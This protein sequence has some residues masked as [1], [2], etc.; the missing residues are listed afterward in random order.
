MPKKWNEQI[1]AYFNTLF[2]NIREFIENEPEYRDHVPDMLKFPYLVLSFQCPDGYVIAAYPSGIADNFF[3]IEQNQKVDDVLRSLPN[4]ILGTSNHFV[5]GTTDPG[6][7]GRVEI[8]S[9]RV[10]TNRGPLPTTGWKFLHIATRDAK[11]TV[12][13]AI[14]SARD[15]IASVKARA[16]LYNAP[17]GGGFITHYNRISMRK[18]ITDRL[19]SILEEYRQ[20]ISEKNY[21]ERIIHRYLRDHPVLL[22]PTKKRLLYEYPLKENGALVH[23][24]DFVIEMTTAR[25]ILVELENPKHSIFT[26]SGDYSAMVNH[27]ERQVE[28]WILF[29][30]KN[31]ETVADKLPSIVAP[32]GMLVIGRSADFSQQDR[33]KLRIHNEKHN[34]KLYTYDDLAEEAENHIAHILDT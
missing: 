7:S 18:E 11:W 15:L 19:Y 31:P 6:G 4:L 26:Q 3:Y 24:I 10:E 22:F 2:S 27:A 34:I 29:L 25:Y 8:I 23:K 33:E 9:D 32:E 28:D 5:I 30:R 1:Y 14:K 12:E 21:E 17:S 16:V 20:I 13:E